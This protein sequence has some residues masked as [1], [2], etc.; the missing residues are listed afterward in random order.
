[1]EQWANFCTLLSSVLL[2]SSADRWSWSLDGT[3]L[4][5]VGF[6]RSKIDKHLLIDALIGMRWWWLT[7][8]K[9]N[10]FVWRLLLKKIPT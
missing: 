8:I 2:S 3:G 10:V 9:V 4:Y 1:M 5:L 7:P 6:A